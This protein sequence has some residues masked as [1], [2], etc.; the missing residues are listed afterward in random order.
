MVLGRHPLL[1]ID[2][3]DV[4]ETTNVAC[5]ESSLLIAGH[6]EHARE[7]RNVH[8]PFAR[9]GQFAYQNENNKR[10]EQGRRSSGVAISSVGILAR[11]CIGWKVIFP[12]CS[13]ILFDSKQ[14]NGRLQLFY[15]TKQQ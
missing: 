6:T 3:P 10:Q 12:R 1:S 15:S 11:V 13:H 14:M 4:N 9:H 7:I 2:S 5:G 8:V